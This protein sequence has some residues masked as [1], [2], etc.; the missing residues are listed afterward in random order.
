VPPV[1]R[2]LGLDFTLYFDQ[3]Q[4]LADLFQISAIPLT[5]VIDRERR[6][7]LIDTGG[8]DWNS[9][10]VRGLVEKWLAG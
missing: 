8:R 4:K 2:K 5:L 1:R 3:D 9:S 6:I 7:L 10:E